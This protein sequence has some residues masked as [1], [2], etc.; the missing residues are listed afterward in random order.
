MQKMWCDGNSWIPMNWDFQSNWFRAYQQ[1]IISILHC[2]PTSSSCTI[3]SFKATT[4]IPI[5]EI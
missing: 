1:Q 5:S 3:V 2:N 4:D